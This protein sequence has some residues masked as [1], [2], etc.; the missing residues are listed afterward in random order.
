MKIER[1]DHVAIRVK[2]MR[3]ACKFFSEVFGLEF[4]EIGENKE[5]D[6]RSSIN[7]L[8][9]EVVEPLTP[10]GVTAKSIESGGEGLAL[11]SLKVANI[12]EAAAEMR[13]RGIKEVG[14]MER[15]GV[16]VRIYH[17]KDTY[18][19]MIELIEYKDKHPLL[20]AFAQPG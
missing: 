10:G 2:N 17:P 15:A 8:G 19:V 16:K 13:A 14:K 1:I 6:V 11:L 12:D 3:E 20:A 18:G 5:M 9:I 7:A 4:T